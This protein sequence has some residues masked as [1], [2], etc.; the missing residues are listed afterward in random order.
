MKLLLLVLFKSLIFANAA[1]GSVHCERDNVIFSY[2]FVSVH[3]IQD[4]HFVFK[5]VPKDTA[6]IRAPKDLGGGI[7]DVTSNGKER[8]IEIPPY[9]GGDD[10]RQYNVNFQAYHADDKGRDFEEDVGCKN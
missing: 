1:P 5:V 3:E 7:F 2:N 9:A 8:Y 10:V 4:F 6:D